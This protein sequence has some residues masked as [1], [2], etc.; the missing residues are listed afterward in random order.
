MPLG[1]IDYCDG[2]YTIDMQYEVVEIP[3][4]LLAKYNEMKRIRDKIYPALCWLDNQQWKIQHPDCD[5]DFGPMPS[6]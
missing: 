2:E 6:Y 3:E 4:D 1:R 5:D